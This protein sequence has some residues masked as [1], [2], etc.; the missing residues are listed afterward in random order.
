MAFSFISAITKPKTAKKAAAK[1]LRASGTS[2]C[3]K[4][5]R[6]FLD[7]ERLLPNR[8]DM[9]KYKECLVALANELKPKPV[10]ICLVGLGFFPYTVDS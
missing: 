10:N 6:A 9:D 1:K 8:K 2:P 5:Q 7:P 4:I 3:E